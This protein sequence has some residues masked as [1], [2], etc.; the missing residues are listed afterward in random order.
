[1]RQFI[2]SCSTLDN[3]LDSRF[4][5]KK[6]FIIVDIECAEQLMLEGASS[7]LNRKPKPI[8]MMEIAISEH[9]PKGVNINPNLLST[10]HVF[11]DRGYEDWTADK[12]C[13]AIYPVE[14]EE[15]VKSEVDT[16]QT[17]NFLFIEKGKKSEWLNT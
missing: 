5:N 4:Q 14:I 16:F 11:W 3:V 17:H 2:V 7:I 12:E 10:F 6:C 13:R 8:W 1:M 9:Q 15:I